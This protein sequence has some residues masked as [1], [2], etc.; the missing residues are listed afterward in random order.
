M[1][2][3]ILFSVFH[4]YVDTEKYMLP[5]RSSLLPYFDEISNL[6]GDRRHHRSNVSVYIQHSTKMQTCSK[7]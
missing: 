1:S 4:I 3:I 2:L 7:K 5:K 6:K